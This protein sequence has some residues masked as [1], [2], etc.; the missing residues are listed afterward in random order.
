MLQTTKRRRATLNTEIL[1]KE[2]MRRKGRTVEERKSPNGGN[3]HDTLASESM[4]DCRLQY[5]EHA[6]PTESEC[7]VL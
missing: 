3:M 6:D 7:S 1:K 2:A 4:T 5:E